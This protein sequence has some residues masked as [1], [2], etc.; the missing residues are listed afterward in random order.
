VI[1][2]SVSSLVIVIGS[3]V[4][5]FAFRRVPELRTLA[6][7]SFAIG[8]GFVIL[9]P[10]TAFAVAS[11]SELAGMAERGPIGLFI[12]WL[13]VIGA[14]LLT[15]PRLAGTRVDHQKSSTAFG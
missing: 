4:Y 10:L 7:F 6:K 5:G 8:I 2:A 1:F 9:G 12:V 13:G 3:F 11:Q 14:F 15:K